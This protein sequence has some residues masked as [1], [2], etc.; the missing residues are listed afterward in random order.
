ATVLQHLR[1]PVKLQD[2]MAALRRTTLEVNEQ[3]VLQLCQQAV[4]GGLTVNSAVRTVD[5]LVEEKK[6]RDLHPLKWLLQHYL[7]FRIPLIYP[8]KFLNRHLPKVRV[9]ASRRAVMI[10]AVIAFIGIISLLQNPAAYFST[11]PRFFNWQGALCYGL[12]VVGLK[13]THEFSHAFT[14]TALG[15]RVRSMGIAF[16]VFWPLPFCDITDA[17]KLSK[18]RA[19]AQI[20]IAGVTA[21]L[22]VAGISLCLWRITS[23]DSIAHSIFFITSSASLL[24]T[25]AVN[26]NPAMRFDGYYIISDLWGIEN[27]QPRA[28]AMTKWALHRWL[29]GYDE[30][31]PELGVSRG[32]LVGMMAYSIYT[33]IYRVG[34]YLGIAILVYYKF[35]KALGTLLFLMEIYWFLFRPIM[36]EG[37]F[38]MTIRKKL[39]LS[40]RLALTLS[41]LGMLFLWLALPLPRTLSLP[42]IVVPA[43]A[44]IIYAHNAGQIA[45]LQEIERGQEVSKGEPLLTII[46]EDRQAQIRILQLNQEMLEQQLKQ[47]SGQDDNRDLIPQKRKEVDQVKAQLDELEQL[48]KL[49]RLTASLDGIVYDWDQTLY[50]GRYVKENSVL[51]RIAPAGKVHIVAY[52]PGKY[53]EDLFKGKAAEFIANDQPG[54]RS[55]QVRVINPVREERLEHQTLSSVA[56]GP[57]AVVPVAG[58]QLMMIDIYYRLEAD[59]L[60]SGESAP[61]LG[62]R[63]TLR[64]WTSPRSYLAD[65]VRQVARVLQSESSF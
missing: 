11:F 30:P 42:A 1:R 56:K 9:L 26:L 50:N 29:L 41:V 63:G 3:E 34:L 23:E 39:P 18:R 44:Q 20:G 40:R 25:L 19:R 54:S 33:W 5:G 47:L 49:N 31:A 6:R 21:E 55:C 27:L 48:E 32:R 10:Y 16:M 12:A 46:S 53:K 28:F 15:V 4:M 7:F 61:R 8:E 36:N 65:I 24:S 37:K 35:A 58:N 51:G 57:I 2:L 62:Q 22:V 64:V 59:L 45:D 38:L 52:V 43:E 17:W 14:A 60:P 13:L